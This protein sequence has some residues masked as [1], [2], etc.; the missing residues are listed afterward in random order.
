MV[1][2]IFFD[3]V[4]ARD[5]AGRHYSHLTF[6]APFWSRYREVFDGVRVVSRV[7]VVDSPPPGASPAEAPGVEFVA[8]PA[9]RGP[10]EYVRALGELKRRC[11]AAIASAEA[12]ILRVPSTIGTLAW[13]ILS[14]QAGRRSFGVEVVADPAETLARGAV[15]SLVRPLARAR[16]IRAMRRQCR[17][18][19]AAAYVA[20]HLAEAY[21][22][23]SP[24]RATFY[25][26]IDLDA[27]DVVAEPR[28]D[29][30]QPRRIIHVGTM[31]ARY[32]AQDVLLRAAAGC[33]RE[34]PDVTFIGDGRNRREYES[35]AVSLGMGDRVRFAGRLPAGEAVRRELDRADLF[36]LPST[37]EGLPKALVEA[38]ARGLPCIGSRVGGIPE[39]LKPDCLVPPGDVDA[40]RDSI[41]AMINDPGRMKRESERN[42]GI[43]LRYERTALQA[44]RRAFYEAV[45]EASAARSA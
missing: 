6:D 35:L 43:A 30:G 12:V 24:D 16:Q 1:V 33:E 17:E 45:R 31:E 20:R 41:R 15:R 19:C 28:S 37:T 29:F 23:A 9:Y 42:I 3:H 22:P 18:A 26:S 8:L 2:T 39:L 11:G 7:E 32:K 4:F 38:M 10:W 36:V 13:R 34:R 21:P 14:G 27:A 25:S 40:L 44:Q 5:A